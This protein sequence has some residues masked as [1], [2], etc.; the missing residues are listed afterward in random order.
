MGGWIDVTQHAEELAD[1]VVPFKRQVAAAAAITIEYLE[2][3]VQETSDYAITEHVTLI[4]DVTAHLLGRPD[5]FAIGET[6]YAR[7]DGG[8]YLDAGRLGA[9]PIEAVVQAWE[10]R[11]GRSFARGGR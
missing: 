11:S 4:V 2:Y 8:E 6:V 9:G 3:L 1:P 5:H 7:T 10:A